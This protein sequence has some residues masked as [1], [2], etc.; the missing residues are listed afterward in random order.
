MRYIGY[1]R[2]STDEK[3]K[4]VL[5]IES[6][7]EELKEFARRQ[8]LE[9]VDYLTESKTAKV[10]GRAVFNK[11]L[12]LIENG[13]V[14]GIL[15]WHPDRLARNSVDGGKIIY[16]LDTGKLQ[17]LKFPTLQ[18]DN[19]PQGKFML[20]I[21][22]GQSKYYVDNLS[23]NVK[24][25]NRHKLKLGIWPN[26]APLGYKNDR[27]TKT[28]KVKRGED[29][30]VE[31]AFRLFAQGGKSFTQIANYMFAHGVTK[32]DGQPPK[33]TQ[34]R[35]MLTNPFYVGHVRYAGEIWE[36]SHPCFISK[37]LFAKVQKQIKLKDF[38]RPRR[39]GR[40]FMLTGFIKCAECGA[41]ITAEQHT[42]HYRRTK[43]SATYV[44]YRCT[45]KAGP[46][47]QP[48]LSQT[49]LV[50]QLTR[51]VTDVALPS[52]WHKT[53]LTLLAK[54]EAAEKQ[55][56]EETISKQKQEE[57]EIDQR[58]DLLLDLYLEQGIGSKEYKSRKNQL[59][60][61]KL[62]LEDQMR[63]TKEGGSSWL[64]PLKEFIDC[65]LQAQKSRR[66]KIWRAI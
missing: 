22:F 48:Y 16:L 55:S 61:R 32:S 31:K 43:R 28:I 56:M 9:V 29:K 8:G 63:K 23:E 19:S 35:K 3:T 46:C 50:K 59:M 12:A 14:D 47:N 24:R 20:S 30:I 4:Q 39:K 5:S 37:S 27:N 13:Q 18:F 64:E 51:A 34:V 40:D 21:A 36:A 60:N 42:K 65:T 33:I 53:W 1:C 10:P 54:D 26:K 7:I 62:T 45:K 44:Y 49:N 17:D 6:Q 57:K 38:H 2:K 52:S 25:G 58:L 11:L 15:S 66:K 41:S